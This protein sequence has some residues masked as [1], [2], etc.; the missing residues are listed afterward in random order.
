[1]TAFTTEADDSPAR[2]RE[3]VAQQLRDPERAPV[4]YF[5]RS[6]GTYQRELETIFFRAGCGPGT[7]ARSRTRRL[8]PVHDRR[9]VGDRGAR[10]GDG[11]CA[12]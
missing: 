3:M 2:M 9:G 7:S 5:Y 11:R 12:A 10:A 4:N 1:M 8:F 6:P